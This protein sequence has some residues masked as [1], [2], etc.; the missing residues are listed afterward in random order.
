MSDFGLGRTSVLRQDPVVV[1]DVM[2]SPDL[3][4]GEKSR[5]AAV[6]IG[7]WIGVPLIKGG[8]FVAALSVHQDVPRDWTAR[9]VRLVEET[10][11]RTWAAVERARA[12]DAL[13]ESEEKYRTLFTS[14]DEAFA[15]CRIVV[16]ESGRPTDYLLIDVNPAFEEMTGI[17]PEA[18]EG[19]TARELVPGIEEWWIETYGKVA[20]G[21]ESIRFENHVEDMDRWFDAYA[22]PVG[23]TGNGLFAI[24]FKDITGRKR[25]DAHLRESEERFRA[26]VTASSDVVYNMNADWTEMRFLEGKAFIADTD[27]PS[28]TWIEEYIHPDDREYILAIV[29]EAIRARDVFE[30][31]HRVIRVTARSVGPSRAP[32]RCS[33]RTVKLPDGSAR[34]AT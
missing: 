3:A 23:K 1:T 21:G 18:A 30:L 5:Y 16:D 26:F 8:R 15:L 14:I 6:T 34:H 17:T 28:K 27:D 9:E 32:S 19:K 11:E 13:R 31:E 29:D 12:E 22:T 10:A 2:A 20:L 7:A 24:V 25:A 4:D 33:M